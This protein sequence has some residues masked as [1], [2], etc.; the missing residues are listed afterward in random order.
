[1]ALE[2]E[3]GRPVNLVRAFECETFGELAD[4]FARV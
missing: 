2:E 1:M 3:F 4:M